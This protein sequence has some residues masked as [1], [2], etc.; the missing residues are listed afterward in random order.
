MKTSAADWIL[1]YVLS[2]DHIPGKDIVWGWFEGRM[3]EASVVQN[4]P[5]W[6]RSP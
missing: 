5:I 1:R 3:E 6:S 4:V 2:P